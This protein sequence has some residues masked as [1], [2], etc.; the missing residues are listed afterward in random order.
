MRLKLNGQIVTN[1]ERLSVNALIHAFTSLVVVVSIPLSR[2]IVV[3][4]PPGEA[5]SVF[6]GIL[7]DVDNTRSLYSAARRAIRALD[8]REAETTSKS[9]LISG[10]KVII[11]DVCTDTSGQK[12]ASSQHSS[13]HFFF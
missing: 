9:E 5:R 1:T 3:K 6:S 11:Y 10:H 13:L 8:G 7:S 2:R 12:H 4:S